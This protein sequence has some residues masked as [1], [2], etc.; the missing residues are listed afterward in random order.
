MPSVLEWKRRRNLS[1]NLKASTE[2]LFMAAQELEV[3]ER[4]CEAVD[5]YSK[6]NNAEKITQ[7]AD[8]AV[9]EGDCFLYLKCLKALEQ[10]PDQNKLKLLRDNA[11]KAGLRFYAYRAEEALASPAKASVP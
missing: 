5:F 2:T 11:V 10:N 1:E 6:A 4:L 3:A 8:R 7:I 9:Q